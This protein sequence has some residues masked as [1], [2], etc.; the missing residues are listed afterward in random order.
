MI[1]LHIIIGIVA[2]TVAWLIV[3][4][5]MYGITKLIVLG[6]LALVEKKGSKE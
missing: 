5:T 4:G 2:F 6:I 1:V 3:F